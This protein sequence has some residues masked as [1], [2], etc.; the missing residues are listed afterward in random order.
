VTK[1]KWIQHIGS[2]IYDYSLAVNKL[3]RIFKFSFSNFLKQRAKEAV[4]YISSYEDT[5]VNYC[6]NNGCD[7][8]LCGHIHKP[9]CTIID[10][11]NYYN[12]GDFIENNSCIIETV[13]GQIKLVK[14]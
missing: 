7:S 14:L 13:D 8:V 3:F 2:I 6:K 9:E 11:I 10:G 12:T 1:N 4:K 5:V